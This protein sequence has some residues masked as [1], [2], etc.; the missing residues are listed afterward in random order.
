MQPSEATVQG[1]VRYEGADAQGI[2]LVVLDVPGQKVNTLSLALLPQFDATLNEALKDSA[3]RALVVTSGK[4]N[5]FI[6]G[7]DIKDLNQVQSA[8]DGV[9]ISSGGHKAM[10][11][12]A[13]CG[14]PTVAAI[15][16]DCL[17]G[18]LELA[19]ACTARVTSDSPKTKLALPEVQLGLLPGGGGTVRLPKLVG[20]ANSLDMMLTGR[21]IRPKKA[22][23]M[24]LVDEIVPVNQLVSAARKLAVELADGKRPKRK[25]KTLQDRLLED[26]ALGRAL[27]FREARK[28]VMKQ[29]HGLYPAPLR[30]LDVVAAGTYKAEADGF[31]ALLMTAESH[32]LRHLFHCITTLKKFDGPDTELVQARPVEHVGM[33]GAGLMV[34]GIATVLADKGVT[35]RLK[36]LSL[37]AIS[38]SIGYAKKVYRKGRRRYG[39]SGMTERLGRLSG[40]VDYSGFGQADV[41]IEAVLEKMDLKH[42]MIAD[43][44]KHTRREAIFATNTSA[45]PITEI[46][47]KAAHPERVIGMHF[48]SP[49][50]KMPLVEVIV[51]DK[52]DPVVTKTISQLSRKMGKHVIVVRD[53]PGF[54]TTRVLAPYMIEAVYMMMEGY[55]IEDIDRAATEVGFPV[56]PITLMDEV[57]ID[58]G[59]KVLATMRKHY[60]DHMDFPPDHIQ[61]FIGEGRLG[62]KTEKGFYLYEK[63][64]RSK[65]DKGRKLVDESVYQHLPN[66][67]QTRNADFEEMGERLVLSLVN[68]A[69]RCLE[70]G[71][72][73]SAEAGDLGAVFGIGFPPFQ[74]GPMRYVDRFGSRNITAR[75]R[76]LELRFGK[77]FKPTAKLVEMG[78]HDLS[79]YGE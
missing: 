20:L 58:V 25:K 36:D 73:L 22:L 34:S 69:V 21:T 57:G 54:Y 70:E 24:G 7:A 47:A 6:A 40:G 11:R 48:F 28:K 52:T 13:S 5:G 14:V 46:A 2:G 1:A 64:G 33:L 19:L 15:H 42:Q 71:I 67:T 61:A 16:G 49:V 26:N 38:K 78:A 10:E 23:K 72:L 9:D 74:G 68:E 8:Q 29:T 62:K 60:S 41:V 45:L 43:I 18:G 55:R 51:T 50:E 39:Q 4:P 17:G 75:L 56:G 31:G 77:R 37:D 12:L 32:G 27:V 30:I 44:E 76:D 59:Q 65:M 35:V 79:F 63:G 66:G 53:C 3:L